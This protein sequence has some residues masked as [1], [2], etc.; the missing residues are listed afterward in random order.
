MFRFSFRSVSVQE[1]GMIPN[2]EA[3]TARFFNLELVQRLSLTGT[4]VFGLHANLGDESTA[5][6]ADE[7]ATRGLELPKGQRRT[8]R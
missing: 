5:R 1:H 2:Y 3:S 8:I 4:R 7:F 6:G